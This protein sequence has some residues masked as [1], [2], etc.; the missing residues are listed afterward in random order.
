MA[1]GIYEPNLIMCNEP[2]Y[3]SHTEVICLCTVNVSVSSA[4][5][6]DI[7]KE[8]KASFGPSLGYPFPGFCQVC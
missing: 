1:P 7:N 5:R 8:Q 4:N 6:S 3:E 2:L